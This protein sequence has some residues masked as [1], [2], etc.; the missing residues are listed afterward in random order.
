VLDC[1]AELVIEPVTSG[2]TRWFA[3]TMGYRD[4]DPAQFDQIEGKCSADLRKVFQ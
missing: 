1:F 2:R 4:F 3:M